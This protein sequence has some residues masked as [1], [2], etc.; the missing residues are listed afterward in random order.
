VSNTSG[1]K[2]GIYIGLISAAGLAVGGYLTAKE[3]GE[4]PASMGGSSGGGAMPPRPPSA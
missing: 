2:I 1:T 4:L 3:R